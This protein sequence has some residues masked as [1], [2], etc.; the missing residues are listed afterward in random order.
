MS[1]STYRL[2]VGILDE[3]HCNNY[4][5]MLALQW[6]SQEDYSTEGGGTQNQSKELETERKQEN[7]LEELQK[8]L[9]EMQASMD[10]LS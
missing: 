3:R 10:Q 5:W 9:A 6:E 2:L 7:L 8:T 4:R 1:C